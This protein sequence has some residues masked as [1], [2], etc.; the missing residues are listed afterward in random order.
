[1]ANRK[2]LTDA[3]GEVRELTDT[4][5]AQATTLSGLPETLRRKI[6]QRGPQR[7][8]TKERITI[9]LS[10]DVVRTFRATGDGWQTRMDN[11]L[12]DWLRTHSP[13]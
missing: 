12:K 2:P 1:M 9:R 4:D 6:G 10:P 11:A 13:A 7:A 3:S 5:L 8:P